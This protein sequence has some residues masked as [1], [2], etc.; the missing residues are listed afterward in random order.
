MNLWISIIAILLYLPTY[1]HIAEVVVHD[2]Y[3]CHINSLLC[4]NSNELSFHDMRN[5]V[6]VFTSLQKLEKRSWLEGTWYILDR[7]NRYIVKKKICELRCRLLRAIL[8]DNTVG[9]WATKKYHF[10]S[11]SLRWIFWCFWQ[12]RPWLS[13]I[14][15]F[16]NN[17]QN[18]PLC[19]HGCNNHISI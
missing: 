3:I 13:R 17:R 15:Y 8:R 14:D 10:S 11:D 7:Y 12:L 9:R 19:S 18:Y 5:T 1:Y 4:C 16:E 6:D 2:K